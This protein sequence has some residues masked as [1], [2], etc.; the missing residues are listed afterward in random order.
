[1]SGKPVIIPEKLYFRIGEVSRLLSVKPHVLR[2]WET[3]FAL[4]SPGKSASGQRVYRRS[5]VEMLAA[6]QRLLYV[7]KYSIEGARKKLG[8]LRKEGALKAFKQESGI[9]PGLKTEKVDQ[10]RK[11]TE[12]LSE[13]ART[14][15]SRLFKI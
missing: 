2:Y 5:D 7:E 11:L 10:L 9:R 8:L 15:I 12:E 3:E 1:M 14:P 6:I 13:L 4:L